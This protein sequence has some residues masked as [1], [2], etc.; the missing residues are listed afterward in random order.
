MFGSD[1]SEDDEAPDATAN[2]GRA[3][4]NY[5]MMQEAAKN[6]GSKKV[7]AGAAQ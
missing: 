1:S 4:V 6:K 5:L 7:R 3:G 2:A